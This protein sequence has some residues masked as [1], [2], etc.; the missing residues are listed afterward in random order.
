[1]GGLAIVQV[2]VQPHAQQHM[3]GGLDPIPEL[4]GMKAGVL[5]PGMFSGQPLT[6]QVAFTTPYPDTGYAITLSVVTDGTK[7]FAVSVSNKTAAG[8]TVNLNSRIISNLI[9]IGWSTLPIGS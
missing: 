3:P 1:M 8:F 7:T 9:E 6:S 4:V 5:P 2:T